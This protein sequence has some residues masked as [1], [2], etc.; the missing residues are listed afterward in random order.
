[1]KTTVHYYSNGGTTIART[2]TYATRAAAQ[3]AMDRAVK[4]GIMCAIARVRT[5]DDAPTCHH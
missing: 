5:A 4:R 2:R 1:M 3:R